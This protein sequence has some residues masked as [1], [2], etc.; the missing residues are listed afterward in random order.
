MR[1]DKITS[2]DATIGTSVII[3]LVDHIV[4]TLGD[5]R[6]KEN[7]QRNSM[8]RIVIRYTNILHSSTA[9]SVSPRSSDCVRDATVKRDSQISIA[10]FQTGSLARDSFRKKT[11][12][13]QAGTSRRS[14][15][16][17]SF[18]ATTKRERAASPSPLIIFRVTVSGANGGAGAQGAGG[19]G[20]G[21]F[22]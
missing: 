8:I 14:T 15:R 22:R 11:W 1:P 10:K 5:T 7:L 17:N 4:I 21:G 16:M 2:P 12:R 20:G 18:G 13:K 6:A 19:R 9:N 3:D